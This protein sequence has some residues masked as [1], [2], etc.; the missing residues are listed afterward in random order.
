MKRYGIIL[1]LVLCGSLFANDFRFYTDYAGFY[2]ADTPFVELYFMLPRAAMTHRS[3]HDQRKE[4]K[5]IIAVNL[6]HEDHRVFSGSV[7]LDDILPDNEEISPDEHIPGLMSLHLMP[8]RY[9]MQVAVRDFYS[10]KTAQRNRDIIIRDLDVSKLT[11][12]DIQIAS[13]V[14]ETR[15]KNMFTK[16]DRYDV[17][18]LANPEFDR[19]NGIFYTY[20]EIYRL[21]PGGSY[22]CQSSIRDMNG[23]AVI[24]NE[25]VE[26]AAPGMLEVVIDRMDVRDLVSG[27]YMYR[28]H[29]KD[30]TSGE[31]AVAEKR[32]LLAQKA[33]MEV[34][35]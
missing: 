5:F 16:L 33:S 8:G 21:H 2:D 19:N 1:L 10:G 17:I 13:Y 15:Q 34:Y 9:A 18:P 31:E 12:S 7:V 25:A 20:Y 14:M 4:G 26:T 23:N 24:E 29:V 22:V 28:V 35:T 30:L 11:L 6:Y 32:I 27:I 3:V